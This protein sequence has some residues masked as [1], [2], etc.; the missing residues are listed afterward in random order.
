MDKVSNSLSLS[1]SLCLLRCQVMAATHYATRYRLPGS[2][3]EGSDNQNTQYCIRFSI[4]IN[5]WFRFSVLSAGTYWGAFEDME[6]MIRFQ[7]LKP[8]YLPPIV[9]ISDICICASPY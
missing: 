6:G 7:S 9:V 5:M 1:L 8:S 2:V 3:L 4:E